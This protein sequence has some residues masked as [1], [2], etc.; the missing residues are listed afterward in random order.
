MN[1]FSGFG[2]GG[3][4][5][6]GHGHG[7]DEDDCILSLMQRLARK[8]TTPSIT[9]SWKSARMHLK[10]T[11]RSNIAK[12]PKSGTP[13][14]KEE[15]PRKYSTFK[16]VQRNLRGLLNSWRSRKAENLR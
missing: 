5:F 8:S 13:T 10:M 14:E 3:F 16:L 12:W 4:P 6:G 2:G 1:F 9:R 11:S 7:H 15:M